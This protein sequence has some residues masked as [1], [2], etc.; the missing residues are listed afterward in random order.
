MVLEKYR[1][2]NPPCSVL[3]VED[4]DAARQMLKAMLE[5]NG[6]QVNEAE[7][8]HV[9]LER[10]AARRPNVILLDLMMPEMDGFEFV[11]SLHKHT[12]WRSIPVV[13][14]TAKDLSAEERN[15]LSGKVERILLKGAFTREEL[16]S[17]VREL[18][19]ACVRQDER[20]GSF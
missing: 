14:L 4:D 17:N 11:L 13:V 7:N 2:D 6:W 12:E 15:R 1:C 16:L 18:V 19:S 3:L 10:V 9:A 5:K 8:G 20:R